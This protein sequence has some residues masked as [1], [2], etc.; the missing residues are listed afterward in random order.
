VIHAYQHFIST[1]TP[2]NLPDWT[3]DMTLT[4]EKTL[5]VV[6]PY[7][8]LSLQQVLS[9]KKKYQTPPYFDENLV[10]SWMIQI[11]KAVDHLHKH[12]IVHRDLKC[13]NVLFVSNDLLHLVIS[14]LGEAVDDLPKNFK[15]PYL[16][17]W[18]QIGGAPAYL[19]PELLSAKPGPNSFL[20][21]RVSD[22]F[23]IGKIIYKLFSDG[24]PYDKKDVRSC[25]QTDYVPLTNC[26]DVL[27]CVV[28]LLLKLSPSERISAKVA[29]FM[30]EN[31]TTKFPLEDSGC[32]VS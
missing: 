7:Y 23:S 13:D 1:I 30:L 9:A 19:A 29:L 10:H 18:I 8:S 27:S 31:N 26:S 14:D 11:L 21:Y 16:S 15:I 22:E 25:L 17:R 3:A 20:D 4:K 28:E 12:N 6:L 24:D 2:Q 5:I 32:V